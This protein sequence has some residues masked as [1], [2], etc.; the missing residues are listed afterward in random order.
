MRARS[1]QPPRG[2]RC[3]GSAV[4]DT[5]MNQRGK[6]E[7]EMATMGKGCLQRSILQSEE[8]GPALLYTQGIWELRSKHPGQEAMQQSERASAE[9][10]G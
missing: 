3:E 4:G 6:A 1:E 9:A 7:T 8:H 10:S 5:G 2:Q